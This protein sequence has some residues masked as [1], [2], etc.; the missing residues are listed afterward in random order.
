M[1]GVLVD[2]GYREHKILIANT[3]QFEI[4]RIKLDGFFFHSFLFVR[5][6]PCKTKRFAVATQ[7]CDR[8]WILYDG[9]V[10]SR[11]HFYDPLMD[12]KNYNKTKQTQKSRW[13]Y[14]KRK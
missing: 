3:K 11:I 8:L 2:G 5:W 1:W 13:K 10:L 14:T 9:I 6:R 12:N 7:S 4:V